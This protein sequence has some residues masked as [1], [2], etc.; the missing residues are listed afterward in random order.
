FGLGLLI[1]TVMALIRRIGPHSR[2]LGNESKDIAFL[3]LLL[4]ATVTG[5][6][7]EGAGIAADPARWSAA[8]FS[9]IGSLFA[10][11]MRAMSPAGYAIVWWVHVPLVLGVIAA[12]PY[13]RW[14]H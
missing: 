2:N 13:G 12:L 5:F 7:L 3:A 10:T 4:A 6:L 11:P 1:G 9:P 14:L 8:P